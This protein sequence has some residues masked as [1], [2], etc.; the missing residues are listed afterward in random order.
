[1]LT[2][3][4]KSFGSH[5]GPGFRLDIGIVKSNLNILKHHFNIS[6]EEINRMISIKINRDIE[7]NWINKL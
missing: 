7:R 1:M 3:R 4:P 5:G 2:Q 6:E